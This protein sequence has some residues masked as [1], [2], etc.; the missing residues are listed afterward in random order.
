LTFNIDADTLPA[1]TLAP[2]DSIIDPDVKKPGSG[3]PVAANGQRYLLINDIPPQY[4]YSGTVLP[5]WPGLTSGANTYDIIEFDGTDWRVVFIAIDNVTT[6][7]V[8]NLT[9]GIQYRFSE[10]QWQKSWEGFIDAGDFRII[11]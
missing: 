4:P 8:T 10:Y 9:S 7:Y 2:V 1:N 11:L 5:D 3:L 6:E